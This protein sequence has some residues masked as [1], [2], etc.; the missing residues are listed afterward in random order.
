MSYNPNLVLLVRFGGY[1]EGRK[2]PPCAA[3]I[4][5]IDPQ[6]FFYLRDFLADESRL[7]NISQSDRQQMESVCRAYSDFP[8]SIKC[9]GKGG[10]CTETSKKVA[11]AYQ[12]VR[13]APYDTAGP[14]WKK[15]VQYSKNP[16]YCENCAAEFEHERDGDVLQLSISFASLKP[17]SDA[18]VHLSKLH[19]DLKGV[20][21][22]IVSHELGEQ[23][24]TSRLQTPR[25]MVI[26]YMDAN[27]IVNRLLRVPQELELFE[28]DPHLR[29]RGV[30]RIRRRPR[31]IRAQRELK[32]A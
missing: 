10:G 25:R 8:V 20:A 31:R 17:R 4:P 21:F 15:D 30:F 26:G 7:P 32:F 9:V 18:Y 14:F 3:Q 16:F 5:L 22:H 24:D 29:I 27:V 11:L 2:K 23:I 12:M 19:K 28:D 1:N 13:R 6:G